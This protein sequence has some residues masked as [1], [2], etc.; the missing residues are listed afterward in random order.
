[1]LGYQFLG[2]SEENSSGV[3]AHADDGKGLCLG[4]AEVAD[5]QSGI[6]G[7]EQVERQ[8]YCPPLQP[9]KGYEPDFELHLQELILSRRYIPQP[10]F[11]LHYHRPVGMWKAPRRINRRSSNLDASQG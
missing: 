11:H 9:E 5:W 6:D 10:W 8:Q 2:S 1:M 4:K 3:G 7:Q